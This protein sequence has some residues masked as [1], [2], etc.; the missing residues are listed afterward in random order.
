MLKKM[1]PRRYQGRSHFR[2]SRGRIGFAYGLAL[3]SLVVP[4]VSHATGAA[5]WITLILALL[6]PLAIAAVV[7]ARTD[8]ISLEEDALTQRK[9]FR[10]TTV[11][12]E[13]IQNI[14]TEKGCPVLLILV[15]GEKIE[16]A[17][18]GVS[19]IGN[20]LRAWVRAQKPTAGN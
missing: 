2:S 19:A 8:F 5:T 7:E 14:S 20:S 15:S 10:T 17:D 13:Q 3:I 12:R 18:L 9:H 4:A 16:L 6:I 1:T 11:P